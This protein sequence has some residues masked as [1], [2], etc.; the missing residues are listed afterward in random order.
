MQKIRIRDAVVGAGMALGVFVD[1]AAVNQAIT[2]SHSVYAE[3]GMHEFPNCNP[4]AKTSTVNHLSCPDKL[5]S[6]AFVNVNS[7]VGGLSADLVQAAAKTSTNV[8]RQATGGALDLAPKVYQ[9]PE[10]VTDEV[11]SHMSVDRD[12]Q[13]CIDIGGDNT[14]SKVAVKEMPQLRTA[15]YVIALVNAPSCEIKVVQEGKEV[16]SRAF[17]VATTGAADR[18]ID[19]YASG[20]VP[21]ADR[22]QAL[23]DLV[24]VVLHEGGHLLRLAHMDLM[25]CNDDY[26]FGRQNLVF[27]INS[28]LER[29]S[30]RDICKFNEYEPYGDNVMGSGTLWDDYNAYPKEVFTAEQLD[31]LSGR[32]PSSKDAATTV[33]N[34]PGTSVTLT[35]D[36]PTDE[37]GKYGLLVPL[38][39][40]F[41]YK[42]T[43]DKDSATYTFTNIAFEVDS[44]RGTHGRSVTMYLT[45]GMD[46]GELRMMNVGTFYVQGQGGPSVSFTI[47]D[48]MLSFQAQF[49]RDLTVSLNK[50]GASS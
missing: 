31:H 10:S 9:A 6:I 29:L 41:E 19:V 14:P 24:S 15:R 18:V 23:K 47:G 20:V 25:D 40:P 12:G 34:T 44:N 39:K 33:L 32:T 21:M 2:T 50:V 5:G 38:P 22:K 46:G 37:S 11:F 8:W 42:L 27:D 4:D 7:P 49:S 26:L 13:P 1:A 16:T 3:T 35:A 28:L 45:N 43:D 30:N 17:G 48:Q 36:R